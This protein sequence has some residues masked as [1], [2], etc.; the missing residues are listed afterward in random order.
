[1]KKTYLFVV[2]LLISLTTTLTGC[3]DLLSKITG[4]NDKPEVDGSFE[5]V[6]YE[7]DSDNSD[8]SDNK[9]VARY[10]IEYND[11]KTVTDT[12]IQKDGKELGC[13]I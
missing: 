9:V 1:M 12:L 10:T 5:F 2:L 6:I 13:Y 11:C 7:S 4:N 8:L 3:S